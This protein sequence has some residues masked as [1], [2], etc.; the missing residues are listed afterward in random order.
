MTKARLMYDDQHLYIGFEC[1][2]RH[3]FST[4]SHR[5]DHLWKQDAVEAFI[6]PLGRG[7]DYLEFQVSPKG[8]IFDTKVH[9]HP[10]RDDSFD[11]QAQAAAHLQGTLNDDSNADRSW[12]A[13]L[14]VP[15]GPL[16]SPAPRPGQSWRL[17]LFRLDTRL[18]DRRAFLAWSPP[19]S[20]TT[21][22]PTRFGRIT[23]GPLPTSSSGDGGA[24]RTG[25]ARSH[26]GGDGS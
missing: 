23:F 14:A 10:R 15:F 13:E 1:A 21:H 2:D 9:R 6:D 26:Q 3:I 22:V 5:D 11:G 19:L 25:D 20:N 7:R 8:L 24:E 4:F 12:T 17:N 16:G 18:G